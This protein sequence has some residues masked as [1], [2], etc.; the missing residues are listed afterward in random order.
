MAIT[1]KTVQK[2]QRELQSIILQYQLGICKKEEA[3]K[4]AVTEDRQAIL[5]QQIETLTEF[6]ESLQETVSI[7]ADYE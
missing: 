4:N 7:L 1:T 3:L 2:T 6:L 5:E